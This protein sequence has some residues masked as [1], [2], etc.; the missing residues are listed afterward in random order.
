[1]EEGNWAQLPVGID[2]PQWLT[3]TTAR[4]VLAAVHTIVAGQRLLDIIDL[5]ESDPRIQVVFTAAPEV[6]DADV[7][8]FLHDIGAAIIPWRQATRERFDLALAASCSSIARLHA[9]VLVMPHGAGYG[10]RA[11][12]ALGAVYGLDRNELVAEGRVLPASIVLSHEAQLDLLAAQCPAAMPV[13]VVAGDPCYDRL[14]A[15]L[16]RRDSYRSALGVEANQQLVLVASTWGPNGLFGRFPDLVTDIACAL[17]PARFRVAVQL[18]PAAWAHGRRQLRA[19]LARARAAGLMLIEPTMDW[20]GVLVA[21]D[22]VVGDHGSVATYAAAIGRSVRYVDTGAALAPGSA[23]E[24]LRAHATPWRPGLPID[25]Q[26]EPNGD[27][28]DGVRER[29]T[30]LPGQAHRRL[31]AD[32][33]RLLDLPEPASAPVVEAVIAP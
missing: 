17:D 2:A 11:P 19:W 25:E 9:P 26:P 12:S 3:R 21:A 23:Q 16:H 4:T 6:F 13:A 27:L 14:C 5:V 1:M 29:L 30:S 31:R 10:K 7:P 20:R 24:Y 33:Y 22:Q 15:S 8:R 28:A 32:M 18:H